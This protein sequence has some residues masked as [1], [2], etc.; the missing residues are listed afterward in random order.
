MSD[1]YGGHFTLTISYFIKA[2][3]VG[4]PF[5]YSSIFSLTL[6]ALIVGCFTPGITAVISGYT[7]SIVGAEL[8][9]KYLGWMMFSFSFAQ[10][11]FG[12][13]LTYLFTAKASYKPMFAVCAL[14]LF[15]SATMMILIK[16][17]TSEKIKY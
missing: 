12:F 13:F 4:I 15:I 3:G 7:L 9:K 8:H 1:R 14:A 10:A 17:K 2:I 11:F 6:S 16:N 5:F